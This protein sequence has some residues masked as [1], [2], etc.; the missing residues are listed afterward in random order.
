MRRLVR[1]VIPS[2]PCDAGRTV[3]SACGL[4][5]PRTGM[6]HAWRSAFLIGPR[7]H[8]A[9]VHAGLATPRAAS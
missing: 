8:I 2:L 4:P 3:A 5:T 7:G 6:H 1:F 9:K